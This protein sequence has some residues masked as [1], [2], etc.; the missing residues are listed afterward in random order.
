MLL[1][2]IAVI[3]PLS[4]AQTQQ[5]A[6]PKGSDP[7]PEPAIRAILAAFD[8]YEVVGMPEGGWPCPNSCLMITPEGAPSLALLGRGFSVSDEIRRTQVSLI[9]ISLWYQNIDSLE[10]TGHHCTRR[11]SRV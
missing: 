5:E 11:V 3:P 9:V 2:L 4:Q 1:Y 8:K 6:K 7:R 10:T